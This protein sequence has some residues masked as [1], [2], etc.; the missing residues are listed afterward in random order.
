[1]MSIESESD[2]GQATGLGLLYRNHNTAVQSDLYHRISD[3]G[4][5]I[6]RVRA[7]VSVS[8]P[9]FKLLDF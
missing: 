3:E 8:I 9:A 2:S 4:N 7:N 6:G 1:M 5:K